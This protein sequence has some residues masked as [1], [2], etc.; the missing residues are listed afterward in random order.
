[1]PEIGEPET[2]AR[3]GGEEPFCLLQQPPQAAER[4]NLQSE[5]AVGDREIVGGVREFHP[6]IGA[7]LL[8]RLREFPLRTGHQSVR[9]TYRS[10]DDQF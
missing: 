9:T 5:Y 4:V 8:K 3:Q 1:M 2:I 10:R 6:C 7:L